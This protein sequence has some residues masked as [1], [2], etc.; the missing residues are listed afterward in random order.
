MAIDGINP[1]RPTPAP[2]S[3][4]PSTNAPASVSPTVPPAAPPE[5]EKTNAKAAAKLAKPERQ[6]IASVLAAAIAG[7]QSKAESFEA[8]VDRELESAFGRKHAKLL[9]DRVLTEFRDDPAVADLFATLYRDAAKQSKAEPAAAP[10]HDAL[11][12]R[13]PS[14]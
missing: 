3:T 12:S 9:R 6:R 2:A 4:P 8:L 11:P 1:I 5:A 10:P 14:T 7:G 13:P